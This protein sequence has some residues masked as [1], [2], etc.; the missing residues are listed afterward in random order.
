MNGFVVRLNHFGTDFILVYGVKAVSSITVSGEA[1]SEISGTK[2][3]SMQT[4]WEADPALNRIIIRLP[5]NHLTMEIR[6]TP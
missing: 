6:I 3:S 2:F 5:P 1:L 4:G